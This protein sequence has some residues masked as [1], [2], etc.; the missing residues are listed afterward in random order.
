MIQSG[1]AHGSIR[2]P[3]PTSHAPMNDV[4]LPT[5]CY[6]PTVD[7]ELDWELRVLFVHCWPGPMFRTKRYN[8][9]LPQHRWI[10]RAADH[11]L[12]AHLALHDKLVRIDGNPIRVGGIAEVCVHPAHRGKRLV[13]HL[14]GAAH[15]WMQSESVPFSLLFGRAEVYAS[16]GYRQVPNPCRRFLTDRNDWETGAAAGL[17]V[18]PIASTPWPE[19]G[20]LDLRC[21]PF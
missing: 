2:P 15:A 12:A 13:S 5:Y 3:Q 11:S 4:P 16:Q 8:A 19:S 14:L 6:D 20:L 9:E 10:L 1:G 17:L 7:P 21:P 18:R